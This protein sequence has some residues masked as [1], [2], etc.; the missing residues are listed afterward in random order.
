[1][2]GVNGD[3]EVDRGG[4]PVLSPLTGCYLLIVIGEPHCQ[5]HKDIILKRIEKGLLSWDINDCHV[6]LE[7]ELS[8]ITEQS[9]EG[10]EAKYGERLIQFA[11]EN[12]VTEVLIHPAVSTLSQCMKNLLSSFTRHRHIIHSG[13]TFA[14]N[15]SWILQDG[16]FSLA[17]FSEAF[18]EV[19][20][21]RVLKAYENTISLDLHCS[22]EGDWSKLSRES[23]TKNCKLRLNPDDVL[24]SGNTSITN[25][26]NYLLPFL[27]P[28]DIESV[29]ESSDIVGNIRFS[30]PTLYIFPAGQGDAALFGINGFN[31]LVD[32]GF[33]RKACFWNFVRH[34]D[35]LDAVLLTRINNNNVG[36]I[37][38]M[39]R[40]KRHSSVYPQ[41]GHF[42]CNIL[43]RKSILSPDGDKDKDPLLVNLF[44]EG[45]ELVENLHHINLNPQTCY[46]DIEP[47]NLYHKV[48]HGTLDMYV[49]SPA[50]ESKEVREFLQKWNSNDQKLFASQK[51]SRDFNFPVQNLVSI[52]AVLVW[53]PA[54][55]NDNI[56][57]ILFPGSAPQQKVFEGLDK[58]KQLEFFK[59]PT[60]S[61]KS[62]APIPKAK[63][64]K[65]SVIER[66]LQEQKQEKQER[67]KEKMVQQIGKIDG[68]VEEVKPVERNGVAAE[69]KT[70][71]K[72]DSTES[73][74][75]LSKSMDTRKPEE[76]NGKV[77]ED[78]QPT[79]PKIK[80]ESKP[81]V[82]AKP[83]VEPKPV[84]QPPKKP[85]STLIDRKPSPKKV[86]EP[87]EN[88]EVKDKEISPK[89][90]VVS[91]SSPT[92]APAKSA[93]DANNRKVAESKK[94]AAAKDTPKPEKKEA[95][96]RKPISRRTKGLSS[97]AKVPGS[98]QKKLE[99]KI[100]LEKEG[101]TDS[102]TVSTPSADQEFK[103]DISKLTPE[104]LEAI[105][106]R[107][108]AD[109]QEE[110]EV[111]KEIEAV[112]L[113]SE[114]AEN[115]MRRIKNISIEDH[116]DEEYLI[117][118]KEEIEQEMAAEQ[119]LKEGETQKHIR[120]SEESEKLRASLEGHKAVEDVPHLV[121]QQKAIPTKEEIAPT[122]DKV[123]A[124]KE[125][126]DKKVEDEKELADLKSQ[127]EDKFSTPIESGATT[128]PTLPEDERMP[129]EEIKEAV[130][131]E[132]HTKEET[133]EKDKIDST[134][135]VAEPIAKTAV[136]ASIKLD[137]QSQIRDIVKTPDE[138]ADLPVHEEADI[139][140]FEPFHEKVDLKEE[141]DQKITDVKV[142]E[143]KIV[144][145][146][147][148]KVPSKTDLKQDETTDKLHLDDKLEEQ[149]KIEPKTVKDIKEEINQIE[150][151]GTSQATV[152]EK[153][154]L[155]D[156]PVLK[157]EEQHL[158]E[159]ITKEVEDAKKP[160]EQLPDHKA[161][162]KETKEEAEQ[163]IKQS[164]EVIEKKVAEEELKKEVH[165]KEKEEKHDII[166]P[167]EEQKQKTPI[168]DKEIKEEIKETEEKKEKDEKQLLVESSTEIKDSKEAQEIKID[169]SVIKDG[170]VAKEIQQK[171][172]ESID[173]DTKPP[174]GQKIEL[175]EEKADLKAVTEKL[176]G[177]DKPTHDEKQ[178]PHVDT[179]KDIFEKDKTGEQEELHTE[180]EKVQEKDTVK[181]VDGHVEAESEPQEKESTKD[182]KLKVDD[183]DILERQPDIS[184]EIHKDERKLSVS[185]RTHKDERK[186]SISEEIHKDERKLSVS[187]ETHKDER[188]PSVS[189]EIHKD[190][191]K[192]SEG[193][194]IH[195]EERK[196]SVAEKI[197]KEERKLSVSE[198]THK[199]E[200]K[201]SVTEEIHK[202][203]RKLSVCEGIHVE[204]RKPSV[205]EEI[206]KEE[207][208][209]SVSEDIHKDE[210]KPSVT[211]EIHKDE[212]KLS[213][214][215]GI[216]V[217][218]RKPSVAE[219]IH[220]EERKLSV[221]E[222]T[223]KE[224]RKPSVTEEIHKDERKLSV[225]EEI[226]KEERKPSVTE[227]IH[228]EERKLS[229]SEDIHKDERKPSVSEE[230][231]KDERKLSESE[232]T[233]KDERKPS[234]SEEIHKDE[235]KLSVGEGIHK[236]ERK[237]SM[238]EE[239]HKEGQKPTVTEGIHKD[240]RKLSVSEETH[241]DER[242]PSV[243][244]EIHKEEQKPTV[245]EGIHKDE[246]KLSVSEETH[247]GERKPSV[248]EE[249]HKDERK[250]SV[251]EGIQE[252]QKSSISKDEVIDSKKK[253]HPLSPTKPEKTE[254][255]HKEET[256]GITETAQISTFGD[257]TV[258]KDDI[259]PDE[260]MLEITEKGIKEEKDIEI[261]AKTEIHEKEQQKEK[262]KEEAVE[263]TILKGHEKLDDLKVDATD[264][265][266]KQ[267]IEM[268][269]QEALRK[270]STDGE[271]KSKEEHEIKEVKEE[272][273]VE[274]DSER[275][276][277]TE[278]K[279]IDMASEKTSEKETDK[280]VESKV[281]EHK[282][283]G[284][285]G[286]KE[287]ILGEI[288]KTDK[289]EQE[290]SE[291][292]ILKAD[293][294]KLDTPHEK[295][296]KDKIQET[297]KKDTKSPEDDNKTLDKELKQL[298]ASIEKLNEIEK[299]VHEETSKEKVEEH[300]IPQEH[301]ELKIEK[302]VKD[303]LQ[304]V[305]E[306]DSN[307]Q[308]EKSFVDQIM[309]KKEM[310][311]IHD[312]KAQ[313][314][315][316]PALKDELEKAE[317]K[318]VD[319]DKEETTI[320]DEKESKAVEDVK[321]E[322][323]KTPEK[324]TAAYKEQPIIK[325]DTKEMP[326]DTNKLE[327]Q[328][329]NEF[330]KTTSKTEEKLQKQ[331]DNKA[332]YEKKDTAEKEA[333]FK[334]KEE[335][336]V[337]KSDKEKDVVQED[338]EHE[339]PKEE[340]KETDKPQ[341]DLKEKGHLE[342]V[343]DKKETEKTSEDEDKKLKS[344][345]HL[346]E[347]EKS[348][349][350]SPSSEGH[351]EKKEAGD[352]KHPDSKTSIS[353]I[354][355]QEKK[356]SI[357]Q[358]WAKGSDQ[359]KFEHE[360]I[361]KDATKLEKEIDS[362]TKE[363]GKKP[364][365]RE[366]KK[367]ESLPQE[368]TKEYEKHEEKI[369]DEHEDD[370]KLEKKVD[371]PLQE[372]VKQ[373][374]K[375]EEKIVDKHEDVSKLEK[376]VDSPPQ[377]P[378]KQH[379]K[380]EEKIVDKHQDIVKLE[381]KVD[382]P[383]QEPAKQ[384]EK[385]EEKIV[386][387]HEDIVKLEKKV[388]SPPQEPV[389]QHEKHEEEVVDKHD[390]VSKLD[391]K[392][393]SPLK[394][395]EKVLEKP[396]DIH[397]DLSKLEKKGDSPSKEQDQKVEKLEDKI[398][399]KLDDIS[400]LEKELDL[401]IKAQDRSMEELQDKIKDKYE[402]ITT[403]KQ[404][405]IISDEKE[406]KEHKATQ[407][408][409]VD[410]KL[411]SHAL[412]VK[413]KT[414]IEPQQ[415]I[416]ITKEEYHHEDES[417][418]AD[419][420]KDTIFVTK[421]EIKKE[422]P[423]FP[424]KVVVKDDD[425]KLIGSTK[426]G[427][428]TLDIDLHK[429][430]S[431]EKSPEVNIVSPTPPTEEKE[432]IKQD[433]VEERKKSID[434][435][436]DKEEETAE[437][438][439]SELD[440]KQK[441][442]EST[443]K[444]ELEK[445][446]EM[447]KEE[448]TDILKSE[449][450]KSHD[451]KEQTETTEKEKEPEKDDKLVTLK[452]DQQEQVSP[453]KSE[454]ITEVTTTKESKVTEKEP[455]VI[456]KKVDTQKDDELVIGKKSPTEV[457]TT[458]IPEK[459]DK[460]PEVKETDSK[461][462]DSD[463]I[464]LPKSEEKESDKVSD[465]KAETLGLTIKP[466]VPKVD[467][468]D[469]KQIDLE[470]EITVVKRESIDKG[471]EKSPDTKSSPDISETET[472]SKESEVVVEDSTDIH[473]ED[474]PRD[475]KEHGDIIAKKLSPSG[476]IES[477][478]R[479]KEI[480]QK[481]EKI[482][483]EKHKIEISK[484]VVKDEIKETISE[485]SIKALAEKSPEHAP[486]ETKEK[487]TA[488]V[489]HEIAAD[490]HEETDDKQK[491]DLAKIEKEKSA[492]TEAMTIHKIEHDVETTKLDSKDMTQKLIESEKIIS[493]VSDSIHHETIT[494][495]KEISTL[496]GSK[497]SEAKTPDDKLPTVDD[498]K[499][500]EVEVHKSGSDMEARKKDL[501]D[502]A[503]IDS[504]L[505]KMKITILD[506]AKEKHE[507][508]TTDI[509]K[510]LDE[511]FDKKDLGCKSPKERE[512]D[513]FKIVASVAEVLKSDAPLEEFRGK[514]PIDID[515]EPSTEGFITELRE[516]HITGPPLSE[517]EHIEEEEEEEEEKGVQK[518]NIGERIF[519]GV[520]K[521]M[522]GIGGVISTTL[523][524]EAHSADRSKKEESQSDISKKEKKVDTES[525]DS[526]KPD[527][528]STDVSQTKS[529]EH[530]P[531][532]ETEDHTRR[533]S[534]SESFIEGIEKIASDIGHTIETKLFHETSTH[535]EHERTEEVPTVSQLAEV[536]EESKKTGLH[537]KDTP[538]KE[539]SSPHEHD[540]ISKEHEKKK[541]I[542]ENIIE[543]IEKVGHSIESK[544]FHESHHTDRKES[545]VHEHEELKSIE[546]K[547][548]SSLDHKKTKEDK[549]SKDVLHDEHEIKEKP[550][551]ET[552]ER[553]KSISE[554]IIDGIEK[555]I[556]IGEPKAPP[557]A[558]MESESKKVELS[559]THS[560]KVAKEETHPPHGKQETVSE[561]LSQTS[562]TLE[563]KGSSPSESQD[564]LHEKEES[565]TH[566][567][568]QSLTESIIGGIEKIASDI[569]H[570][571]ETKL[572]HEADTTIE[573][574]L[575]DAMREDYDFEHHKETAAF[576][577]T[578]MKTEEKSLSKEK[579][580]KLE[581]DSMDIRKS[582]ETV[583]HHETISETIGKIASSITS[584]IEAKFNGFDT[585]ESKHEELKE[586]KSDH[587]KIDSLS[588]EIHQGATDIKS[589]KFATEKKETTDL[590]GE[591]RETKE[592]TETTKDSKIDKHTSEFVSGS[593]EKV[594]SDAKKLIDESSTKLGE[595][596]SGIREKI[597]TESKHVSEGLKGLVEEKS[598]FIE[599]L[600]SESKEAHSKDSEEII[601][602][603]TTSTDTKITKHDQAQ[604]DETSALDSKDIKST[605]SAFLD[606]EKVATMLEPEKVTITKIETTISGPSGK[607]TESVIM[608]TSI[609]HK[610]ELTWSGK[611]TP[612]IAELETVQDVSDLKASTP[613][614]VPVSPI[615][616]EEGIS[617]TVS[618]VK[619]LDLR[620]STPASDD[621]E[622]SDLSSSQFSKVVWESDKQNLSDDDDLP[623]TP[624][625]TTSQVA[626]SSSSHDLE[627]DS[628]KLMSKFDPMS[629]SLYGALP[630]DSKE[631]EMKSSRLLDEADL[632]FDKAM[633]DDRG[634]H[635]FG[636][637]S[638][639][640]MYEVTTAKYTVMSEAGK[641]SDGR[642]Q[643][644]MTSSFIGELPKE[645]RPQS[646]EG[647]KDKVDDVVKSW[648][649]PLGLPSPAPLNDNKGTPKKE[650][651]I[652]PNVLAKNKLNE[653]KKMMDSKKSKKYTPVYVDLTYVPHFGNSNY[654]A[655][656]FFRRIRAR[657]YVFSGLEP[658]KDVYNALLEAKQ[659][660]EDK[661]LEVT[662][663]P[664]Y[665]TDVLGYWAAENEE[666]LAKHK[667]DF[668]PSASRCTIN[669]QD[670][671][672][673][674]S[675]YRLEFS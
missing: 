554:K 188:K 54:N 63:Q 660:W 4:P 672:T 516:T 641:S 216:H 382:S 32:G 120:D 212:R 418:D 65:G 15:G 291:P 550:A 430:K 87:K 564:V 328:K 364:D 668:S 580:T 666:L 654:C 297:D 463:I 292:S 600:V 352:I 391:M 92:T 289:K 175:K 142:K 621:L 466:E 351:D 485:E 171:E 367:D 327:E 620:S 24:T 67:Q 631:D 213:V 582:S 193:E 583:K 399:D 164:E 344:P 566:K 415:E 37:G 343:V 260:E 314:D 360:I 39:M 553:R 509:P 156:E 162:V 634:D 404:E 348:D 108:L 664:T 569:G 311:E 124:D 270:L 565:K 75:S 568:K 320:I 117:I 47:I 347:L 19:E 38:S 525:D 143:E 221:S 241:K 191:R 231:H 35:R 69:Q 617:Q 130:I 495:E 257:K 416:I 411:K 145:S 198:E 392:V 48:G 312:T 298:E 303:A 603:K 53:Q 508:L 622:H 534:L 235:R 76:I 545:S 336:H 549:I 615:V 80:P 517:S 248:S 83:K 614:T 223:H 17:D 61:L 635:L 366:D 253:E 278:L 43:E 608:S 575:E 13:Y 141:A 299:S 490:K 230:I 663:I 146:A 114:Q 52:C 264:E 295:Q 107:E 393:G 403:L 122:E 387:K 293:A 599:K 500:I 661:D 520:E 119:S 265:F 618:S 262:K 116:T 506:E 219:E 657:Y 138:V 488:Q 178:L 147:K 334:L 589:E 521:I 21:Q 612:D 592:H 269:Q 442:S 41:I 590:K 625:S 89:T 66:L 244:E 671:E 121:Q 296:E 94:T 166:V 556:H 210:R 163:K 307:K 558:Q 380:L 385:L 309:I 126:L 196:P 285:V 273:K 274:K 154:I 389:K 237:P 375:P 27:N 648:G 574:K 474:S 26:L 207:R 192:L 31:M 243:S 361:G 371:S 258:L 567:K 315:K 222:E 189:E 460:M 6:D 522:T 528:K 267:E 96:E 182:E 639:S 464:S 14:G 197:H 228:K 536:K 518:E 158:E 388:D 40:R 245:T 505:Q 183:K 73:E 184:E 200:R 239:I 12:L 29:L 78:K 555:Y 254:H 398:D 190:E 34:L 60:C 406:Q 461:K 259:K 623:G 501:E 655:V 551:A 236:E 607:M 172:I 510:L 18:Q 159:K 653:D 339:L 74:K 199:D 127:P 317:Q 331:D 652:P 431:D 386:D 330:D 458:V 132:K 103:K 42:F 306:I 58:L 329:I 543:G 524:D 342:L 70:I 99:K 602:T 110:Q 68:K 186:P 650:R 149:H 413:D 662:I 134:K 659:T 597:E 30:Y 547:E 139:D 86:P 643:D 280:T 471:K 479:T 176:D 645:T 233:H 51:H 563:S 627:D 354:V 504:Q 268:I 252:E 433:I 373:H 281:P 675:A 1:M 136:V 319:K 333:D 115:E 374:Q 581:H 585:S 91:R 345:E 395:L 425:D 383:P 305:A 234:V 638:P 229:V 209:L 338:H 584:T 10:E 218:E 544:L 537:E 202:E 318:Q 152:I 321:E 457:D 595:T 232:E 434:L 271:V 109:L 36:G 376:K 527:E 487:V 417:I 514:I 632:D 429:V 637:T 323:G 20:V 472:T 489:S 594:V 613:P 300:D 98:P 322:K 357:E 533:K 408:E 240:E 394:E 288:K 45:Q 294:E 665:D 462:T 453:G 414:K 552:H 473:K 105:K 498:S 538:T 256:E 445:H 11:S 443:S 444:D 378:A 82:D 3:T 286:D 591:L 131:E 451:L 251:S 628:V 502:I 23:F 28:T 310:A 674:C 390:D 470:K 526:Q 452:R 369:I 64:T 409:I 165:P 135:K 531:K 106:A 456:E 62:L 542:T 492:T 169:E 572:F 432:T 593:V 101:T 469:E 203:E 140:T 438:R 482:S 609:H 59:Y 246:R 111:I 185:E 174:A 93:K 335:L 95:P 325:E 379:E 548:E 494:K 2:E 201:P 97:A 302:E 225:S 400:N 468:K 206:H 384:H 441:V 88:G 211:E 562:E 579:Q 279:D 450:T 249:I 275:K 616:K 588:H 157:K 25:F 173:I 412:G 204:E 557:H 238:T 586:I 355:T 137:R 227:K 636:S 8:I 290:K 205:A 446:K 511:T 486:S 647:D 22:P 358:I 426:V 153:E 606:T 428:L 619:V 405:K 102:S 503:K 381:N 144:E 421:E 626:A 79:K 128:A 194:G 630:E 410:E 313:E 570:T 499:K 167:L 642:S 669:L 71:R 513:V 346:R 46:R 459:T 168:Q 276:V 77:P 427:K 604:K 44:E 85:K 561:E 250:L 577:T 187:E 125:I 224:E 151:K 113:K 255:E 112:F 467:K 576:K 454:T 573:Q 497:L 263:E 422:L 301:T 424:E 161:E 150:G 667:I 5:D 598:E 57:R 624:L 519:E 507:T 541:S 284:G 629:M 496:I 242:K 272:P 475:E 465:Q 455:S 596:F 217:E 611:S 440:D 649:K 401:L 266:L 529:K 480:E 181:G 449:V 587:A 81:K 9:P 377:E 277:S 33:S 419:H 349:A 396:E 448:T 155:K 571:I 49:L 670:H 215:E 523:F 578:E 90:R 56:T 226:H 365:Q 16:T 368:P 356:E 535:S 483:P 332:E 370:S 160:I 359:I 493:P 148:D 129:L 84:K 72:H 304:K 177:K 447:L 651:K 477:E 546:T 261:A 340:Q 170:L 512:E 100:K 104:E 353:P 605:V 435:T 437:I 372:P 316:T 481:G 324:E 220:K 7:K 439:K 540:P 397:E 476:I 673:S 308:D 180:D 118:E 656:D 436:K 350:S 610:D 283:Q 539:I 55:V 532:K 326:Q 601:S 341:A 644:L 362:L 491:S 287:K 363:Q 478:A 402:E 515:I 123:E 640:Y 420:P 195:V 337:E 559:E 214:S 530:S 633:I 133:K 407:E 208:K 484:E 50:R 560:E 423:Q 658:S 646:S 282:E 247:K 179:A